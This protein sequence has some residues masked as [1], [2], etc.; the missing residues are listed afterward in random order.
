MPA[1][2]PHQCIDL[3]VNSTDDEAFDSDDEI[4]AANAEE[5]HAA[6]V[7][8]LVE[9]LSQGTGYFFAPHPN[10]ATW[11]TRLPSL[12]VIRGTFIA[13]RYRP[14]PVG[15]VVA[16]RDY[17]YLQGYTYAD[18]FEPLEGWSSAYWEGWR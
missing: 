18:I 1:H 16:M 15:Y 7:T 17:C 9:Y 14:I 13:V 12:P 4:E 2:V 3:T 6:T 11:N 10:P 5:I 8:R